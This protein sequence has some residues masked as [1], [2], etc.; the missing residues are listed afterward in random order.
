MKCTSE[1]NYKQQFL[2]KIK[3][4]PKKKK[5]HESYD[6]VSFLMAFPKVLGSFLMKT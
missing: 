1:N 5:K 4:V 3:N 6:T 2:Y